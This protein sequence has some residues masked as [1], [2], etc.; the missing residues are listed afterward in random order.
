MTAEEFYNS[1]IVLDGRAPKKG[2][3]TSYSSLKRVFKP[4]IQENPSLETLIDDN[5]K[6][7]LEGHGTRDERVQTP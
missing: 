5:I 2:T 4:V 6:L 1:D 7:Y 3:L